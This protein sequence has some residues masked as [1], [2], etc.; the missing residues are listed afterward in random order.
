MPLYEYECP[1][2]G[3]R[4]EVLIGAVHAPAADV[5]CPACGETMRHVISA[6]SVPPDG[7]YSYGSA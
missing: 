6:A 1:K 4:H 7:R 5:Q 2:C 3:D